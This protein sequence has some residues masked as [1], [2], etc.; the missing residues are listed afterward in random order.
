MITIEHLFRELVDAFKKA[1]LLTPALDARILL[2]Y[3]LDLNDALL[4]SDKEKEIADDKVALVHDLMARRLKHEPVARIVG[5]KE[6]WSMDFVVNAATLIPRPDSEVL[7]EAILARIKDKTLPLSLL[8]LGTGSGCLLLTLL[9]EFK[10]ASGVGVD[11]SPEAIATSR[12]NATVLGLDNRAVF[13]LD[14]WGKNLS[15]QFDLIIT[16]PPYISQEEYDNL[17]LEVKNYDPQTALLGGVDGLDC[18][19]EILKELPRLLKKDALVV[20][21]I[22]CTQKDSVSALIKSVGGTIIEYV[23]D[24]GQNYRGIIFK[25]PIN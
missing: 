6:F 12:Q 4:L 11:I 14:N 23:K 1:N 19:R 18:Y 3:A 16:N 5:K 25:L 21:E 10:N 7:I 20:F 15:Q 9:K 2:K 8:D 13:E 24:L 17:A 22:G